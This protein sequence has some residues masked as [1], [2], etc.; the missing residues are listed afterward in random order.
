[1]SRPSRLA[2]HHIAILTAVVISILVGLTPA[3]AQRKA[4]L[5]LEQIQ[6]LIEVKAP[7]GVIASEVNSRRIN[8]VLTR[9]L[10]DEL[11]SR[12]LGPQATRVLSAYVTN[13]AVL[14][15]TQPAVPDCDVTI[16]GKPSGRTDAS[17]R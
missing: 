13:T 7:D 16:D 17:G 10:L 8:F 3:L 15:E 4:P 2:Q 9:K 11:Q 12:G 14:I 5:S 1:M 6:K